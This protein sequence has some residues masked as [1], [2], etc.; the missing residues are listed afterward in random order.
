MASGV[1]APQQSG[2]LALIN[3]RED[4]FN[5]SIGSWRLDVR[6][7]KTTRRKAVPNDMRR[8]MPPRVTPEWL[9]QRDRYFWQ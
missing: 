8:A 2:A 9:V 3:I 7:P 5:P 6:G 1:I 4:R